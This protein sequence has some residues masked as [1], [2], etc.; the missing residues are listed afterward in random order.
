MKKHKK[1][2]VTLSA[3]ITVLLAVFIGCAVYVN[4]YYYA[5]DTA[6]A[7]MTDAYKGA[8]DYTIEGCDGNIAFVPN[9]PIAGLIFYPGGKVEH[10]A[11]AP[12]MAEFAKNGVL[13]VLVEMPFR[14]AVLDANAADGIRDN[15]PQIEKWYIG[16]HSLGGAMAASYVSDHTSDFDGLLLLGAYSTADI[17]DSGLSVISVYGS[18]DKVLN[19]E[20]YEENR[21]LLPSGFT[22]LIIDGGCHSYFGNY[23]HQDGDGE[24][25]VSPEEQI[26]QTVKVFMESEFNGTGD[27]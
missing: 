6:I 5:G 15:F 7:A 25:S 4:D 10:T 23:G 9:E 1:L 14:L 13:C 12:L 11:Y 20:K 18:E 27:T 21:K 3:L 17:S 2:I 22:E 8:Y 26:R 16:G 24:P 19:M